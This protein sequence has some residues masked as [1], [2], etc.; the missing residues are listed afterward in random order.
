MD[1]LHKRIAENIKR[2]TER[3]RIPAV[4]LVARAGVSRSSFYNV[5]AGRGS[6]TIDWLQKVARALDCDVADLVAKPKAA[7]RANAT[8]RRRR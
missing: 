6:P 7:T 1:T 4:R 5:S 2:L 8:P 3:R